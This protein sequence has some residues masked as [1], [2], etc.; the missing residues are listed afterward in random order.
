MVGPWLGRRDGADG[1][2]ALRVR[3]VHS[4]LGAGNIG[5]EFMARAF[6]D[7]LPAEVALEVEVGNWARRQREPYPQRHRYVEVGRRRA[8]QRWAASLRPRP[9][10]EAALLVGTTPVAE[11]EGLGVIR[12]VGGRLRRAA[13]DGL[14]LDA[15]GV[16]V[17]PLRSAEAAALFREGFG[18]VRTWTVRTEACRESLLALGV[19]AERVRVGADWAWLYR[20]RR[21]L[22]GFARALWRGLGVDPD[23]PILVA[24]VVNMVWRDRRDAKRAVAAA[25]DRVA[26]EHGL[27]IAFLRNDCRPGPAMDGAA[28]REVMGLMRRP[29]VLVP[30]AYYDPDEALALLR[31]ARVAVGQRYHFTVQ[32]ALAQG[33]VPVAVPRLQ[34]MA[35]LVAEL[36]CLAAGSVERVDADELAARIGEAL[37]ARDAWLARL[38]AARERLARR[39]AANLDLLWGQPPYDRLGLAAAAT[40]A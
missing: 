24:S 25:F 34:K 29:A 14:P 35:G 17:E 36:G 5:D 4:G 7:R 21:P 15:V 18:R 3:H 1:G 28:A 22:R 32:A 9:A 19:P 40:A 2:V 37:A 38:A 33:P 26:A 39:A 23:R 13:R 10:P 6:W 11:A 30:A 27:Q 20:P 12:H 8:L 16:G 31:E